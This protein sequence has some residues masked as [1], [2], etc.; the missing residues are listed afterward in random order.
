MSTIPRTSKATISGATDPRA[1]GQ[2]FHVAD[3]HS[4]TVAELA[5]AI[6]DHLHKPARL[7]AVP[8][9]LLRTA[10]RLTGRLHQVE[11]LTENLRVDNARIR[12]VLGWRPGYSLEEGLERTARWY[13][14]TEH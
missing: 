4:P 5:T 14:T 11:R 9:A 12:A 13:R 2:C 8:P 1:A 10:G 7:V 6:G 3:D